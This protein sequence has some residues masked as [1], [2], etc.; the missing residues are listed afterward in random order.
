VSQSP[1]DKNGEDDISLDRDIQING[2]HPDSLYEDEVRDL[3][4]DSDI[5]RLSRRVTILF[6]LIPCLLCAIFVFGYLQVRKRLSQLQTA[7]SREVQTLSKD[8]L[9]KAASLSDQYVKLEK[10]SAAIQDRVEKVEGNVKK[11]NTSKADKKASEMADKKRSAEVAKTFA[12]LQEDVA[13][14]KASLDALVKDLNQRLDDTLTA[15]RTDLKAQK[16]EIA[17]AVQVTKNIQ[18]KAQEQESAIRRLSEGKVDKEALQSFLENDRV[19]MALLEKRIK[20]LVEEVLWLENRLK[21]TGKMGETLETPSPKPDEPPV[22]GTTGTSP[23]P[24]AGKIIEQEI[25]K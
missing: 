11:L 12:A 6:V 22:A 21:M 5:H 13:Q 20:T 16:K 23:P 4:R 8:I 1:T 14:Q 25:S 19:R 18:N 7:G 24:E 15:L 9:N 17:K 10:T 3:R 2:E